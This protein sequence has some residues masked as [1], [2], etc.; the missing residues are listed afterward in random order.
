MGFF[1][2]KKQAKPPCIIGAVYAG[3]RNS[4]RW[5]YG[6]PNPA[7]HLLSDFLLTVTKQSRAWMLAKSLS[8]WMPSKLGLGSYA[9]TGSSLST[10]FVRLFKNRHRGFDS[11]P[12]CLWH[13]LG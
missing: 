4:F 2:A 5:L 7:K 13:L 1:I 11:Q 10:P 12:I 8:A 3:F 6:L 9:H